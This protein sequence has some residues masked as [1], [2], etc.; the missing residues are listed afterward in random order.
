MNNLEALKKIQERLTREFHLKEGNLVEGSGTEFG[1]ADGLY[2]SINNLFE[3]TYTW[4]I[5][6]KPGTSWYLSKAR[7][8]NIVIVKFG[9]RSN[10]YMSAGHYRLLDCSGDV[11]RMIYPWISEVFWEQAKMGVGKDK[12]LNTVGLDAFHAIEGKLKKDKDI[13]NLMQEGGRINLKKTLSIH[14]TYNDLDEEF[15]FVVGTIGIKTA[16]PQEKLE[17][18]VQ[19]RLYPNDK[20]ARLFYNFR[21]LK[22]DSHDGDY[23]STRLVEITEEV[24]ASGPGEIVDALGIR[25]LE[26]KRKRGLA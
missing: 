3:N 10:T 23:R 25:Y 21:T 7:A 4:C 2:G 26:E 22:N 24:E 15:K 19:A 16:N 1:E 6:I 14:Y 12:P 13:R 20:R 18:V 17:M 11:D 8:V 5:E 9:Y